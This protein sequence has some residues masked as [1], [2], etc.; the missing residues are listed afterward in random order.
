MEA[1]F[2]LGRVNLTIPAWQMALYVA[3][4]ALYMILGRVKCC[5]LTTYLFALY[6]GY[7]LFPHDFLTAAHGNPGAESAYLAFGFALIA[8][9]LFALFYEER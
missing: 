5:F 3:L 6:W 9:N 2:D 8:F 7:Y 1:L 4:V